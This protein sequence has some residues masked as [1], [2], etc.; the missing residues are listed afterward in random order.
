MAVRL[1]EQREHAQLWRQL[2]TIALDAPL[3]GSQP[4]LLRQAADPELLGG[5]CQTLR[6]GPI[7]PPPVCSM[8]PACPIFFPPHSEPA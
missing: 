5:L 6:F 3:E 1:R 8:P 2:T 4:G 7:D